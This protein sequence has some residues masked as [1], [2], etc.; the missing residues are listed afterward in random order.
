MFRRRK[1]PHIFITANQEMKIAYHSQGNQWLILH[2]KR[3][4]RFGIL[5]VV[6]RRRRAEDG[7][8]NI[9]NDLCHTNKW[10]REWIWW[11]F[12]LFKDA[13]CVQ[14]RF[15]GRRRWAVACAWPAGQPRHYPTFQSLPHLPEP[16]EWRRE[17]TRRPKMMWAQRGVL[18]QWVLAWFLMILMIGSRGWCAPS[19]AKRRLLLSTKYY[20]LSCCLLLLLLCCG[21]GLLVMSPF[22]WR[23]DISQQSNNG[24][25]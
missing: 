25:K 17:R 9:V 11:W 22:V 10:V 23:Q 19:N 5:V 2:R 20:L 1:V 15:L 6:Q 7:V 24:G 8:S 3:K 4:S 12:R 13:Y 16:W 18:W 21:D 14:R